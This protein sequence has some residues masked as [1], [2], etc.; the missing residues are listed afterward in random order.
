MVIQPM[1]SNITSLLN[2]DKNVWV[3]IQDNFLLI[4]SVKI[5][6]GDAM[7]NCNG[8][9]LFLSQFITNIY[10]APIDH[11]RFIRIKNGEHTN[12]HVWFN[13]FI[14]IDV[15]TPYPGC[16]CRKGKHDPWMVTKILP[17]DH[18][19]KAKLEIISMVNYAKQEIIEIDIQ[20]EE[21]SGYNFFT[22]V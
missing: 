19:G 3:K 4:S 2:A 12:L 14:T 10:V 5:V 15:D 6:K 18:P 9:E 17:N 8:P 16:L 13:N 1:L 7:I 21:Y 11:S 22:V 20:P